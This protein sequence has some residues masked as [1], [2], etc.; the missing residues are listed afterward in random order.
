M[1]VSKSASRSSMLGENLPVDQF[2]DRRGI[3]SRTSTR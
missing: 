2:A 1:I 3:A